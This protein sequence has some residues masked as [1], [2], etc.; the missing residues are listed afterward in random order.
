MVHGSSTH[1]FNHHTPVR[2]GN[3]KPIL[4]NS[5]LTD[6]LNTYIQKQETNLNYGERSGIL[7]FK[8]NMNVVMTRF[9]VSNAKKNRKTQ[10]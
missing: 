2:T 5:Q 10:H 4:I 9:F 3:E 6:N 7:H 1:Y 8:T